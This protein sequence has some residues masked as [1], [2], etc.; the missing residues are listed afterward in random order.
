AWRVLPDGAEESPFVYLDTASSR[1]GIT[2]AARKLKSSNIAIVGLGGTG[3]YVLDFVA[4]TPVQ[5]IHLFDA[6]KFGQHNAFRAPGAASLDDLRAVPYKVD[7]WKSTYSNM[8]RGIH[9]HRVAIGNSNVALLD[10][11]DYV[12]ICSDGGA[13][14]LA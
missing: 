14:K 8:H 10:S 9:A 6:D 12:F 4:K 2:S 3:S 11:M 7:L 1:A 5:E 13:S